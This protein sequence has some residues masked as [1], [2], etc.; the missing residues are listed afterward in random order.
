MRYAEKEVCKLESREGKTISLALELA[1]LAR[2]EFLQP[3][4]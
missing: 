1:C 4:L 2:D 3:I